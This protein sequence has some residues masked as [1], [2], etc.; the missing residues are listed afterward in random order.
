MRG[1]V[2]AALR[3]TR[4][5]HGLMVSL[6]VLTGAIVA[7]GELRSSDL[8][9]V[10]V[11]MLV[12]LLVEMGVFGLNDYFNVE[13]DRV[14]APDRP[15]VR[16]DI[17]KSEALALSLAAV[18]LGLTLPWYPVRLPV[19]STA[20][21]YSVVALDL[22]YNALLKRCGPLGN[23][24]VALSTA[25]PFAYG[26]LIVAPWRE[27]PLRLW[28]FSLIAFLAALSRE[29][30]KD[31]IDM[32]GDLA[33]GI[34][35]LPHI[36]GPRASCNAAACIMACAMLVSVA[37][38]PLAENWA[39]YLAAVSL[40]NLVLAHSLSALREGGGTPSRS[41]LERFRRESLAGMALGIVAFLSSSL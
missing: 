29:I 10:A 6:A 3:L 21:L 33:A 15:L 35:T 30:V 16:G 8:A 28:A 40:T 13:E 24:A 7:R 34:R 32:P 1:K 37:V 14:N 38:T 9:A 27:V 26:A 31:V 20:L 41:S 12:G 18:T 5:E 23:V 25:A 19:E 36:L 22:A 39:A 4:I 2:A 11:G 17:S